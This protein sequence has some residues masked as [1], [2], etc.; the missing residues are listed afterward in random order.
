MRLDQ[1]YAEMWIALYWRINENLA[2]HLRGNGFSE[3]AD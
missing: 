2:A 1:H 3:S